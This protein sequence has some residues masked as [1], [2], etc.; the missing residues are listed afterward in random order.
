[1]I[2]CIKC[3]EGNKQDIVIGKTVLENRSLYWDRISTSSPPFWVKDSVRWCQ[4]WD[5]GAARHREQKQG[6][7]GCSSLWKEYVPECCH[8]MH[9]LLF[10]LLYHCILYIFCVPFSPPFDINWSWYLLS[11]CHVVRVKIGSEDARTKERDI[12]KEE[13]LWCKRGVAYK[14]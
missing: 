5:N 6:Q 8:S 14:I 10:L 4:L 3:Y 12:W 9:S 13:K 1:M 2:G 7:T 11:I